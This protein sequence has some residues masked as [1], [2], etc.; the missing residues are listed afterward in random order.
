[1]WWSGGRKEAR[2]DS[3]YVH[4]PHPPLLAS[5][6]VL[7]TV[8]NTYVGWI[9]Y[10]ASMP[11][12]WFVTLVAM[13]NLVIASVL[14]GQPSMQV[15]QS[16][17]LDQDKLSSWDV[18]HPSQV[19]V[20]LL[21][22]L[23]RGTA[24]KAQGLRIGGGECKEYICRM[25]SLQCIDAYCM[26]CYSDQWAPSHC[27][28]ASQGVWSTSGRCMCTSCQHHQLLSQHALHAAHLAA[29]MRRRAAPQTQHTLRAHSILQ[30]AT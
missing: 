26:V 22:R 24:S 27:L 6:F 21:C 23:G 11:I 28:T 30:T 3:G 4:P 18:A 15:V 5:D 12:A 16:S 9:P 7:A 20:A 29:R 10:S 8:R 25:D 19:A 17:N 13:R 1:M 2:V 14:D